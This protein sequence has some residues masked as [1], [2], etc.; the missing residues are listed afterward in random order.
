[1]AAPAGSPA[2]GESAHPGQRVSAKDPA[3]RR[4]EAMMRGGAAGFKVSP[5]DGH[6]SRAG[7]WQR[8]PT[9]SPDSS[10]TGVAVL[11]IRR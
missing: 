2:A 9:K 6:V 7:D 10:V 1:M 3:T 5:L 8:P 11:D 4:P